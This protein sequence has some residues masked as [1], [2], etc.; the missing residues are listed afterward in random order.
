MGESVK[1]KARMVPTKSK[2]TRVVD[3]SLD[4]SSRVEVTMIMVCQ[5][6]SVP[7][8]RIM[9]VR[10]GANLERDSR[11]GGIGIIYSLRAGLNVGAHTV[12]VARGEGAEVRE[13]VESD[14]IFGCREATGSRVLRD[15]AF[16]DIVGCFGTEEEAI[17]TNH[18]VGSKCETLNA[19]GEVR[20]KGVEGPG[21]VSVRSGRTLKTSKTARE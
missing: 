18:G 15:T 7:K 20:E 5:S 12:V 21:D 8:S 16:S 1:S 6:K 10:L 11:G 2:T 3:F 9:Y 19:E 14:R 17:T 13:T 4:E